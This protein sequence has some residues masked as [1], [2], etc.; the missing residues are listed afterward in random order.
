MKNSTSFFISDFHFSHDNIINFERTQFKTIEDHDKYLVSCIIKWSEQIPK[1]STLYV[2]GDFGSTNYLWTIDI[3]KK[4]G[5]KCVFMYGNHDS[6]SDY[7]KFKMYFDEVYKY[8]I[9]LSQKLVISHIPVAV[10]DDTINVHGHL[11]GSVLNKDN[12]ITCSIND[13]NY[14]PVSLKNINNN[15]SKLPKYNR[16]FLWEPFADLMKFKKE[17]FDIVTDKDGLIDLSASRV[18]HKQ[19]F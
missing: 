4:A 19:I 8:P 6:L 17:R 2:L 5:I 7:D 12:Y 1:G 13:V 10:F 9:Y 11:H 16:R 18:L 14:K 15:F 3:L